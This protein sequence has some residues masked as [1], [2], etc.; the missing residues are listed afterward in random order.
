MTGVFGIGL[1]ALQ[2]SQAGLRTTSQNIANANTPGYVRAELNVSNQVIGG[3]GGVQIEGVRRAADAFLARISQSAAGSAAESAARAEALDR[4]QALFGDPSADNSLF[5]ALDQVFTSFAEVSLDPGST[6]RRVGATDNIDRFFANLNATATGL[7][8]LI[9]EIDTRISD[10]TEQAQGHLN[11]IVDLNIQISQSAVGGGEAGA[12]QNALGVVL[13]DLAALMDIRVTAAADGAVEVR[14]TSGALLVGGAASTLR[15]TA[16]GGMYASHNQVMLTD[17]SGETTPLDPA[18]RSGGLRGLIDSRDSDLRDMAEALGGFAAALSEAFN[19]VH[20]ENTTAPAPT[21]LSGRQTGLLATDALNFEGEAII[22]VVDAGGDLL[23]RLHIDFDART[24]TRESN[25]AVLNFANVIGPAASAPTAF[26]TQLN[27]ML[28]ALGGSASF[29]EGALTVSGGANGLLVQQG[30]NDP[31]ARAD[32][33]FGQFFGLN[34]LIRR[35]KPGFFET[36]ASA[37]DAHG[38]TAGGVL[39]FRVSDSTGAVAGDREVAITGALAAPGATWADLVT[40]LNVSGPGGL[41]QYATV[42]FVAADGRMTIA[43]NNGYQ[44]ELIADDT[45]RGDTNVSVSDLFGLNH[46]AIASRAGDFG[47]RTDIARDPNKLALA[48]PDL[49]LALGETVVEAGDTRGAIALNKVSGTPFDIPAAGIMTAQSTSLSTY[50]AR[51]GGEVGRRAA[52]AEREALSS[53]AVSEAALDRRL[54][55]E[56]VSID[57]ELVR[58]TTYQQNYAAAARVIQAATEMMDLL[59]RLGA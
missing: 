33:G 29:T 19:S 22:G 28:G 13:D 37:I 10:A 47:V 14:T 5:A 49:T 38:L 50:A 57:D 30:P 6:I 41:G 9:I 46:V 27:T 4:A 8:D 21:A 1:S 35:E 16:V 11:A 52:Q 43:S 56:G 58:L 15:H 24:I 42:N 20:N 17:P 2:A 55:V 39:R 25:A 23:D 45:A 34:D 54:A 7:Q 36:G 18:L 53:E 26:V 44:V 3:S 31:S 40:A 48:R 12:A 32:R 51:F 59:T